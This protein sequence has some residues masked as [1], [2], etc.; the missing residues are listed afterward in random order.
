MT[1]T[2]DDSKT[3]I[4]V[5][6][7]PTGRMLDDFNLPSDDVVDKRKKELEVFLRCVGQSYGFYKDKVQVLSNTPEEWFKDPNTLMDFNRWLITHNHKVNG[8]EGEWSNGF[9]G[10][11]WCDRTFNGRKV[12]V[13]FYGKDEMKSYGEDKYK[14]VVMDYFVD[15]C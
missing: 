13:A 15:D 11:R 9:L 6:E 4:R 14:L 10:S 3:K 12:R 8:K 7:G 1:T 5:M 2:T